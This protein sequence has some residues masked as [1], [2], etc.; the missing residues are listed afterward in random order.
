MPNFD[1]KRKYRLKRPKNQPTVV[2]SIPHSEN[3]VQLSN[4]VDDVSFFLEGI[5]PGI[6]SQVT[7]FQVA[8]YRMYNF[9][10]DNFPKVRLGLLRRRCRL[11]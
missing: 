3:Q 11:Q 5:F 10:S 4:I 2:T 8:T 1:P 7:I 6:S 9:S